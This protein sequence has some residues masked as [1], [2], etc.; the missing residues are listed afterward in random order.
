MHFLE[1]IPTDGL[2]Y[3]D[4]NALA[5]TVY[6]RMAALLVAEYGVESPKWDPRKTPVAS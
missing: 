6:D 5:K 3:E 1:P 4:R 2:T